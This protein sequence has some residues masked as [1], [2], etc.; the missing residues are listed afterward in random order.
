M[1]LGVG[2]QLSQRIQRLQQAMT[3]HC[4]WLLITS[5]HNIRYL[6]GF[7]GSGVVLLGR[8]KPLLLTDSRFTIEAE[9]LAGF[10]ARIT[11]GAVN[12]AALAQEAHGKTLG[13]ESDLRICDYMTMSQAGAKIAVTPDLTEGL[14][15]TKDPDELDAI[16]EACALTDM[17]FSDI[18]QK[19]RVVPDHDEP[20]SFRPAV[21]AGAALAAS[22]GALVAS[23][24]TLAASA[25][26]FAVPAKVLAASASVTQTC[27]LTTEGALARELLCSLYRAGAEGISFAPIVAGGENACK[28]HAV[29]GA[30]AIADNAWLLFDFGG[31]ARGYCADL[32]RTV[33]VG[34][35]APK[36][37][38]LYALVAEAQAAAMDCIRP[39]EPICAA[40]QAAASVFAKHGMEE[41]FTHSLG[42]GVGLQVHEAPRI[43][44]NAQGEFAPGMTVTCEPGLYV[45]GVGGVRIEDVVSVTRNG[46][47]ILSKAPKDIFTLKLE[48]KL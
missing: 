6:C 13:I 39:G 23:E 1:K 44:Q 9:S 45:P 47:T 38:A 30:D 19:V 41:Y 34:T 7:E 35:L 18:M 28:P 42:H 12:L 11:Q 27:R 32:S 31:M 15:L 20:D 37:R 8:E 46:H 10:E 5:P 48:D 36:A 25:N 16:A 14:R 21:G 26:T 22:V 4:D 40:H 2:C 29:P 3:R 33:A 43:H 17:A 24:G